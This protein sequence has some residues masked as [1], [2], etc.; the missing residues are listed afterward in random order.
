MHV[1]RIFL[2]DLFVKWSSVEFAI[3][4]RA[5][6][7]NAENLDVDLEALESGPGWTEKHDKEKVFQK[8]KQEKQLIEAFEYGTV[9]DEDVEGMESAIQERREKNK[10]QDQLLKQL[11]KRRERADMRPNM[12]VSW[13]SLAGKVYWCRDTDLKADLAQ[14]LEVR[15]V[16]RTVDRWS[17]DVF[18]VQDAADPPERVLWVASMLGKIVVD[19]KAIMEEKGGIFLVYKAARMKQLTFHV[20]Q[21]FKDAHQDI[22]GMIRRILDPTMFLHE[23]TSKSYLWICALSK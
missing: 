6:V 14:R 4:F 15:N 3:A 13:E 12:S 7:Q 20:T 10:K 17:A 8:G 22:Y 19:I 2:E 21:G 23:S 5:Q 1:L 9:L 18:V 11:E 16:S